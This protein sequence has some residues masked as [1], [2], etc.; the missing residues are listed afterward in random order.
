M[1]IDAGQCI[2][3]ATPFNWVTPTIVAISSLSAAIFA[4]LSIK[5]SREMARKAAATALM[6][7]AV[8]NDVLRKATAIIK[9]LHADPNVDIKIYAYS[10]CPINHTGN[11]GGFRERVEAI[12]TILNFHE[13]LAIGIKNSIYDEVLLKEQ[14]YSSVIELLDMTRDYIEERRKQSGHHT[15][16]QDFQRL[17]ERWKTKPLEGYG[18]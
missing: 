10:K 6:E 15:S 8:G 11:E 16:Y 7:R 5:S 2:T 17:S 14:R 4:H 12:K 1:P 9:E 13:H 18:R 3:I